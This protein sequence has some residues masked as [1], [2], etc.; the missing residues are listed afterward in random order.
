MKDRPM[1]Q[2]LRELNISV[3]FHPFISNLSD[4]SRKKDRM[5]F[6]GRE[7]EIEVV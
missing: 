7:K 6:I 2:S 1:N 3:E 5:P 4:L